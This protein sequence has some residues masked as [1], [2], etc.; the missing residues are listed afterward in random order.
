[1][2]YIPS[3]LTAFSSM[4]TD[5]LLGNT[6]YTKE[7]HLSKD[8]IKS[9]DPYQEWLE[10]QAYRLLK[11]PYSNYLFYHKIQL[12]THWFEGQF[13][14]IRFSTFLGIYVYGFLLLFQ[15]LLYQL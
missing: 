6:F 1:M 2:I 8:T 9:S 4:A 5:H 10:T 13:N 12:E 7:D 11:S 15:R 14:S 3:A